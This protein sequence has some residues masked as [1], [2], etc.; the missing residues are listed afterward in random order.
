M[1]TSRVLVCA[2]NRQ[3]S[4]DIA[5]IAY[6]QHWQHCGK[7]DLMPQGSAPCTRFDLC[8]EGK[9]LDGLC[10][11]REMRPIT[12]FDIFLI[13]ADDAARREGARLDATFA[14]LVEEENRKDMLP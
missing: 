4:Q 7:D 3:Y 14:S 1:T 9:R 6:M 12:G 8:A 13:L 5:D 11:V 2:K 10:P